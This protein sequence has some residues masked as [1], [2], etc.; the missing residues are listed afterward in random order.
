MPVLGMNQD[1]GTLVRWLVA[2]GEPVAEGQP[3][4]EVETD[5]AVVE[6]PALGSGVLANVTASEG[7]EVPTGTVIALLLDEGDGA[8]AGPGS[9]GL[10]GALPAA[11]G[12]ALPAASAAAPPTSPAR[13]TQ[14][15]SSA[16][17]YASAAP[18]TPPP[19]EDAAGAR[20]RADASSWA[21]SRRV[22]ASPKARRLAKEL[23]LDL[24]GVSGSGPGGAVRTA[25][26]T[27]LLTRPAVA[28]YTGPAAGVRWLRRGVDLAELLDGVARAN[29]YLERQ[30]QT[31]GVT[32]CDVLA[33]LTLAGLAALGAPAP[34]SLGIT[35]VDRSGETE[36]CV[37]AGPTLTSVISLSAARA[38]GGIGGEAPLH[39]L[40]LSEMPHEAAQPELPG[41]CRLRV[42]LAS[43]P[44][45]PSRRGALTLEHRHDTVV[46]P[47]RLLA[48]LAGLV[49]D[50]VSAL[51]YA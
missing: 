15:T 43:T 6:V 32:V 1:V 47:A 2:E 36:S 5:K 23:A 22:L 21:G 44:G 40:D 20:G 46:D 9:G 49:E 33:R 39:V 30:S 26:I 28:R 19:P 45:G 38:R 24:I 8:V 35:R 31:P 50:P 25:D 16:T 37:L 14:P 29:S 27:A 3:L 18:P 11:S 7:D 48:V 42:T 10:S 4:L 41:G 12:S 34:A 13:P 51:L 17:P